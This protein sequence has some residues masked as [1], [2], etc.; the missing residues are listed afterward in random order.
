M[1]LKVPFQGLLA[2]LNRLEEE[3]A[4]LRERGTEK[5][6]QTLELD[7]LGIS[8]RVRPNS[9]R[10]PSTSG[11]LGRAP[12]DLG[13]FTNLYAGTSMARNHFLIKLSP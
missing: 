4:I 8:K 12:S 9:F 11:S 3:L 13:K 1:V 10:N 2:E 5:F 7:S 6:C